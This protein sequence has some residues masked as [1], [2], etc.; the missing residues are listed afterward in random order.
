MSQ[1]ICA[2]CNNFKINT[3]V[4]SLDKQK[5]VWLSEKDLVR[6]FISKNL[7]FDNKFNKYDTILKLN[8]GKKYQNRKIL[9]W[10]A[11]PKKNK[12]PLILDAKSAYHNFENHGITDIDK[13]GYAILKFQCPQPYK[14]Q[15]NKKSKM[16]T[17]YR[18][19]HFVISNQNNNKWLKQ[20]YTQIVNS[21]INYTSKIDNGINVII[22]VDKNNDSINL[23]TIKKFNYPE[24]INWF[25]ELIEIN[26]PKL[27]RYIKNNQIEVYEV[28]ILL[29]SNKNNEIT[30]KTALEL[31]KK[32]FVNVKEIINS[33]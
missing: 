11:I 1:K 24:I 26:Y 21:Q 3:Y 29:Y 22:N 18:H 4:K 33:Q 13:N 9:Y 16:K 30:K 14:T 31:M 19:I 17:Y 6:E 25:Y 28:P 27:F 12:S 10:A 23:N 8:V 15:E 5:P 20:I 2:S 32:G 7:N